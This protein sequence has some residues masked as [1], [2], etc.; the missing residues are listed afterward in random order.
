[1]VGIMLGPVRFA[2]IKAVTLEVLSI[3]GSAQ[4]VPVLQELDREIEQIQGKGNGGKEGEYEG[5]SEEKATRLVSARKK[6]LEFLSKRKEAERSQVE[7]EV[8][9]NEKVTDEDWEQMLGSDEDV[10][11]DIRKML[12]TWVPPVVEG[13]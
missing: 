13:V 2:H 10:E 11:E 5:L 12:D 6:K 1:M 4:L 7:V 3:L 8:V 9:A